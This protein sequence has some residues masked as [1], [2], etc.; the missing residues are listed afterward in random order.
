MSERILEG[1][2]EMDGAR[3]MASRA[4]DVMRD[5]LPLC[6]SITGDGVRQTL[7]ILGREVPLE[8]FEVPSGTPVFDWE[9]PLEWNVR[10]AYVVGPGGERVID[11]R[12]HSL[13]LLNYSVP[14]RAT[15]PL[16]EL[17]THLYSI[18]ER[19]DWIPYRT[20]YWREHWGF[21]LSHR[22]L[23]S[24]PDG[25]YEVVIDSSLAPGSLTYSEC[26]IEG[27][28]DDEFLIS[29]HVCHPGLANDNATGMAVA[30]LLAAELARTRPRLSYR[31]LFAPVTIGSMTW[32]RRNESAA[33]ALR[34]GLVIGLLG[35]PGP[36]TYK[37]S[38]RGGTEIDA[39]AA[40]AVRELDP[41]AHVVDF[42]PYGYDERQFCSPGFNLPV[43]RLTRSPNGEY[44]EYHT[45]ADNL[46]LID[47]DSLT[48]S[49]CA[50]ARILSR[51]DSN[52]RLRSRLPNG[53]PRLG[54]RGLFRSTGGSNPQAFEYALL[55][56]LNQADGMHGLNDIA[57]ASGLPAEVVR[58][59][60]EA[61]LDAQLI[62]DT[63]L[64][65]T[66]MAPTK[67]RVDDTP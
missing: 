57:A 13:H 46:D 62:D 39:I 16:A 56:I 15:M 40:A 22:Q 38:R 28:L 24:L 6:R 64:R 30:A 52:H 51:V 48:Q 8:R 19:P 21:C 20:S 1:L 26:R 33:R 66:A 47:A 36:L 4:L 32:L 55:W 14:I 44:A 43:G 10:E 5:I 53:E 61:L 31:V 45:S 54:K 9:V 11:F 23:E 3:A 41:G 58:Q 63:D 65:T 35:G 59:A 18:P 2:Q 17:R 49:I 7:D 25:E 34:G 27:E 12:R 67:T 37:R 29:T 42:S 60:G 50:L